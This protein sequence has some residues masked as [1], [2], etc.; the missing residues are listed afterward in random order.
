MRLLGTAAPLGTAPPPTGDATVEQLRAVSKFLD[1]RDDRVLEGWT[2]KVRSITCGP[3]Y[4]PHDDDLPL[5]RQIHRRATTLA[6][7]YPGVFDAPVALGDTGTYGPALARDLEAEIEVW[8][9]A[10]RVTAAR[11]GEAWTAY[12]AAGGDA[13][14]TWSPRGVQ[15]RKRIDREAAVYKYQ[16]AVSRLIV[17]YN[18]PDGPIDLH[19]AFVDAWTDRMNP[20]FELSRLLYEYRWNVSVRVPRGDADDARKATARLRSTSEDRERRFRRAWLAYN[21]RCLRRDVEGEMPKFL[22]DLEAL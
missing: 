8:R 10:C 18:V 19:D 5:P 11:A 7:Q 21:G 3:A 12:E 1:E 6:D 20:R 4:V 15:A 14:V 22:V 17:R 9:E 16:H 2:T 13:A